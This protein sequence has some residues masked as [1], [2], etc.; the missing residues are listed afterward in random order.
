[1]FCDVSIKIGT[2]IAFSKLEH[3]D[4][5]PVKIGKKCG[6]RWWPKRSK[7]FIVSHAHLKF[8]FVI[9]IIVQIKLLIEIVQVEN[10]DSKL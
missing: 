4:I 7:N 5:H 3:L 1:M 9:S 10:I 8:L 2:P 6:Q